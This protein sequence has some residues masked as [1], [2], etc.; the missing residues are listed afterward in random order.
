MEINTLLTFGQYGRGVKSESVL[1]AKMIRL[2]SI[3]A[4]ARLAV[5]RVRV[6]RFE[7]SSE[8]VRLAIILVTCATLVNVV[9]M[10]L[11]L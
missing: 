6:K 11:V 1:E 5:T 10:W 9:G 3:E 4:R 7:T 8:Q 2:K